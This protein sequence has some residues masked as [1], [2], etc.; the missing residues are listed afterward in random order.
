MDHSAFSSLNNTR[1]ERLLSGLTVSGIKTS[2]T[3]FPEK[4]G[5]MIH[6][7]SAIDLSSALDGDSGPG[8]SPSAMSGLEIR[9][10]FFSLQTELVRYIAMGFV[11]SSRRLDDQLPTPASLHAHY[12]VNGVFSAKQ[13]GKSKK[14]A[15][16]Y[17]PYRKFYM[18]RQIGIDI[19]VQNLRAE[20][21]E[22]ISGFSPAL[23]QLARI[24]KALF[25]SLSDASSGIFAAIP[26]LLEKRFINLFNTHRPE[27]PQ[28]P[29]V[30]D[31]ASWMKPDGWIFVFCIEMQE[32]LFA[33]LEVRLQPV[34]GMV[35]SLP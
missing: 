1:L 32:L 35:E 28:N 33:E 24:D 26:K 2:Q 14:Q 9:N 29:V 21:R 22:L 15:T 5:Q 4:F 7:S 27:L 31:L 8:F 10:V 17:E 20:I 3:N 34:I 6:F 30:K 16:V 23:A 13:K 18:S 11:P 12:E 19:R 25:E